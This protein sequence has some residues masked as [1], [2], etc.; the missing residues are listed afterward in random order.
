[1]CGMMVVVGVLVVSEQDK[2]LLYYVKGVLVVDMELYIVVVFVV[3]CGVLFVVCCV[4]VDLVWCMLLCVV[5]VGLCDDGSMVILLILCE[6]LK[7][8]LQF[9]LLLQ[10]VSDVC[11]VCMMLI[12][13]WYVFEW[14]GVMWIV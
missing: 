1:M 11:V 13:V 8:L 14:V 9:G 12:Q 5:M 2:V 7:Q 10:V 6:L 4:I 3:V